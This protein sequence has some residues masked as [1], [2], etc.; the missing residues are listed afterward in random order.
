[1]RDTNSNKPYQ[2]VPE[3]G[4]VYATHLLLSQIKVVHI[5]HGNS[6]AVLVIVDYK[7]NFVEKQ[8]H[9]VLGRFAIVFGIHDNL[10]SGTCE[11]LITATKLLKYVPF[12]VQSQAS[13]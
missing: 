7:S 1:M 5:H 3:Q 9:V 8:F 2:V 6:I 12:P 4:E 13:R 10:I 11:Q